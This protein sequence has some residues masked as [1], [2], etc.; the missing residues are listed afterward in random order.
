LRALQKV[1]ICDIR[2]DLPHTTIP[3]VPAWVDNVDPLPVAMNKNR[4]ISR[5]LPSPS[6][7]EQKE[8]HVARYP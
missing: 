6:Q 2:T 3:L 1:P 7:E 5:R 4:A 8:L